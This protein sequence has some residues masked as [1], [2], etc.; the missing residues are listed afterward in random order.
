MDTH[1]PFLD[2]MRGLVIFRM[3]KAINRHTVDNTGI[4]GEF[5][6]LDGGAVIV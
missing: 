5:F 1:Y 6:T 4:L 3:F 2:E